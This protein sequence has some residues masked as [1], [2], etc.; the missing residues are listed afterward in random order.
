MAR[1]AEGG[2]VAGGLGATF[3]SPSV[4][5][6]SS[7]VRPSMSLALGYE[8][9]LAPSLAL[10]MELRGYMTLINSSGG[11]FCSGGCVVALKGDA[12][13]QGEALLGLSLQVLTRAALAPRDNERA[14][15]RREEPPMIPFADY[16]RHDGL[17]LAALVRSG[18]VSAAELLETALARIEE[19]NPAL[20]AVIR[21]ARRTG[22]RR[23]EAGRSRSAVC[24]RALSRQGP[25]RHARRRA[26]GQ[27]QP[28]AGRPCRCRATANW[29]A[30]FAPPACSS[31]GARTRPS[32]GS[33]PTPSR[34][35]SGRRATPG[36]WRTPRAVRAA[37]RPRRWP[38]AWCRWPAAAMAA[39]RSAFPRRAAACSA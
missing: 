22:A 24:R 16:T 9:A 8:H 14:A 17:G 10:R 31:P 12:L 27:R 3:M 6:L 18:D 4:D 39:D 26:D 36:R 15:S 2:Y 30:A 23:G 35:C 11:F 7:E 34:S 32:S 28:P 29:C 19:H 38:P 37:A 5:G 13:L 25:D 33:P 1:P 21:T 20:N